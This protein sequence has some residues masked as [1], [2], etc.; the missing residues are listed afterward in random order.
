MTFI[1]DPAVLTEESVHLT[2]EPGVG[3]HDRLHG[4]RNP[5]F[6]WLPAHTMT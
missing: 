6:S 4:Y 5:N 2:M 3:F 1:E